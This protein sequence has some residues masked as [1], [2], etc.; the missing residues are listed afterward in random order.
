M[1][2]ATTLSQ[3]IDEMNQKYDWS[4]PV[5]DDFPQQSLL[6]QMWEMT[7]K[8]VEEPEEGVLYKATSV[9]QVSLPQTRLEATV[10]LLV[11]RGGDGPIYQFL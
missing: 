10:V 2:E 9:K 7:V 8:V 11:R 5:A 6:H 3:F 4:L 1:A